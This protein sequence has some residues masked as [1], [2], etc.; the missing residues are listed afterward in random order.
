MK[1]LS[2][3]MRAQRENKMPNSRF[4]EGTT[5][6]EIGMNSDSKSRNRQTECI[7]YGLSGRSLRRLSIAA[8]AII[9]ALAPLRRSDAQ[10]PTAGHTEQKWVGT[11]ATAPQAATPARVPSF[12]NQ[13]LRLIVHTS[14]SGKKVRVRLSNTFGDQPVLIGAAHIARRASEANVDASSDRK[15][16]FEGRESKTIPPGGLVVSDAVDL[17]VPALS[18]L[19]ISLFLPEATSAKTVHILAKQT[20]YMSAENSGDVT[21]A[22]EFPT[23]TKID[24]WPFLTGVDVA[25][26][27]HR[28]AIVAF[29]SSTTDGDGSTDDENHRWPDVLAERL[30]KSGGA[31]ADLGVLNEGIIGNRLLSDSHSPGQAGGPFGATLER[32][33]DAL[34]QAGLARYQRDVLDQAGARYVVLVL[35]I[36]DILFPG[37]FIPASESVTAQNLIDGNRKL[38]TRA[39]EKGIRVIET[40]I[41]PFED[42]T[43]QNPV[44]K[45][46]TPEKE[47]VRQQVNAWIRSSREFDGVID[48]D[49]VLRDPSHP[50][51]LLPKYDAGDHL[52]ANDAGYIASANAIRL[53][54]FREH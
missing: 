6:G 19:A 24:T 23:P 41:P 54:L 51:R 40:T 43:F 53:A 14:V 8:L 13:T 32:Y 27:A 47:K 35:G 33:G 26:S 31:N 44:I 3:G 20:S 29:G 45:F 38:L 15:V 5:I 37:Q 25:A 17:D 18:D 42:A 50:A 48:F 30:Q 11:W 22:A 28:G 52:H 4:L 36:N 2:T 9:A 1:R 39:H 34:G 49:E 16:T 21:A 46:S 12:H 7:F 10:N